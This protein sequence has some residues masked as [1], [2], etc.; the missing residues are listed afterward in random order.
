MSC[1]TGAARAGSLWLPGP[2]RQQCATQSCSTPLATRYGIPAKQTKA[3]LIAPTS[4][5]TPPS[6]WNDEEGA[7]IRQLDEFREEERRQ[8]EQYDNRF[9]CII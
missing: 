8:R 2:P 7:W 5:G 9:E 3:E 1:T 4:G 6:L